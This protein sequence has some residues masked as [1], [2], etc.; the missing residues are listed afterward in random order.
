MIVEDKQ[1]LEKI[2]KCKPK[3]PLTKI[4]QYNG[5]VDNNYDGLVIDVTK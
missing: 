2:L 3:V 1:Q 5:K 4:I